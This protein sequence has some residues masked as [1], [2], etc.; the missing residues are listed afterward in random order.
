MG[1]FLFA[2]GLLCLAALANAENTATNDWRH[3]RPKIE[4]QVKRTQTKDVYA[5][6]AVISDL[7]SG[8]VLAQPKLIT[9]AGAPARIEVGEKGAP[10]AVMVDVEV[11]VASSGST[12]GYTSE[13][14]DNDKVVSSQLLTL[15]VSD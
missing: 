5:V 3:A 10:G 4:V 2:A 7:N 15:A 11:T 14:R 8:K 6:T 12:A 9:H 13:I 1:K